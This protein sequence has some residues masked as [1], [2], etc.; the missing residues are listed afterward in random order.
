MLAGLAF[1]PDRFAVGVDSV[2][3]SSLVTLLNS[4]PP[5][6]AP[7]R[8]MF[9]WRIR[10][11]EQEEAFL[12]ARS[13]L[14]FAERIKAPLLVGQGVNDPRVPRAESEQFVKLCAPPTCGRSTWCMNTKAT[15]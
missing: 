1:T 4:I 13:P 12:R 11:P 7:M 6:W 8:A 15:G 14:F 10:D 5:Y 3:P 2:G 9:A